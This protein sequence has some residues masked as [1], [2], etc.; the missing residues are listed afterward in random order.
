[1]KDRE[2]KE[3]KVEIYMSPDVDFVY[4]DVFHVFV[5][6][7]EVVIEFGNI[8]RMEPS[9]VI[10]SNKIVLS[11]GNAYRLMKSL[12]DA[13]KS[14]EDKFKEILSTQEFEELN[15]KIKES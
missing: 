4:R 5:G 3:N 2:N 9:K 14:A 15:K 1:M 13:L 11:L 10:I 8:Q 6:A 7:G 12:E